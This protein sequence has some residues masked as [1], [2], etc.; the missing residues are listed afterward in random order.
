VRREI[1]MIMTIV[2]GLIMLLSNFVGT[3]DGGGWFK[4]TAEDLGGWMIIVSAFAVG[5]ASVNLI[6][7]HGRNI[8]RQRKG[9]INS[10]MLLAAMVIFAS[11]GIAARLGDNADITKLNQTMYDNVIA[12]LGAAM[13]AILA[14][15][16][17]SAS[18]RAFRVRSTE[19]TVLL[20]AA[21]L[22]MLGRVPIGE[23]I[24][25]G[26]P[27]IADWL[28][29]VVNTAGQRAIMIGAAVGAFAQSLRVLLGIERGHL[30]GG[31]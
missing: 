25:E 21:V 8:S 5:L 1:P 11:V 6:K 16:I 12:P 27:P 14:F 17:A 26:F 15:Y 18:Y 10:V 9:W 2:V 30:G 7:V 13:F 24:W 4:Q 28:L 3:P 20:I 31:E 22:V 23:V 29:D 19:A